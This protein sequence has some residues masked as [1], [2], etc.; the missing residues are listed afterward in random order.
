MSRR[1]LQRQQT[2]TMLRA[3]YATQT[4]QR[5][6][7]ENMQMNLSIVVN[8]RGLWRTSQRPWVMK[9]YAFVT[10]GAAASNH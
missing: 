8:A 1:K 9:Q 3:M 7:M 2:V 6:I 5:S 10:K 4:G